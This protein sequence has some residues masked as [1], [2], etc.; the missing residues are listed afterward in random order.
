[1][2]E[3]RSREAMRAEVAYLGRADRVMYASRGRRLRR[4]R[5]EA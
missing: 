4:Q 3:E 1:V 2:S 5:P